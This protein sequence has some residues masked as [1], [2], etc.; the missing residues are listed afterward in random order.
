MSKIAIVVRS[1]GGQ[2]AKLLSLIRQATGMPYSEITAAIRQGSPVIERSLF[3]RDHDDIAASLRTLVSALRRA[4]CSFD[5]YEF[6]ESQRFN[7]SGARP[8]RI[9]AS[10]LEN[11][12]AAHEQ[13]L[14]EQQE[15]VDRELGEQEE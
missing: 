15:L 7:P 1:D 14:R 8:R 3:G 6:P 4:E 11:I 9:D 5:I 12:L 10:V 2:G 13:G